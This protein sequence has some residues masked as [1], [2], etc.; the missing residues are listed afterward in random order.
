M[1]NTN[2]SLAD[3]SKIGQ[4]Q[5]KICTNLCL[6]DRAITSLCQPNANPLRRA[7]LSLVVT[8]CA[9]EQKQLA[10]THIHPFVLI[11]N[12]HDPCSSMRKNKVPRL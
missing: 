2:G 3:G 6:L 12:R 9:L 4:K 10:Q 1:A 5:S 8:P 11:R 7:C